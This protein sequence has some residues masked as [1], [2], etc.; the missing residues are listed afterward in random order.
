MDCLQQVLKH[1]VV[2][3]NHVLREPKV[4]AQPSC[5]HRAAAGCQ[6]HRIVITQAATTEQS[7]SA[8]VQGYHVEVKQES[9]KKAVRYW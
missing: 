8:A 2:N 9:S 4:Q 5:M 3:R 6:T 7:T 1:A